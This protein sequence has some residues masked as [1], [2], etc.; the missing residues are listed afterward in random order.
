MTDKMITPKKKAK[1]A[2]KNTRIL[3]ILD[4]S[5]SMR[6]IQDET[7]G[8][9]NAF[10]A[11]QK[12][13]P[14]KATVSLMQFDNEFLVVHNNADIQTVPPL[15]RTT[16]VPR[17]C[18][19]LYD[20]VGKTIAE[21]KDNNPKSTK[22][23]VMI[24]TDGE[25]NSSKE[26]TYSSV[27]TLIEEVE[28]KHGWDVI[29][30]GANMNAA[31][32]GASMGISAARSATFDYSKGGAADAMASVNYATTSLRGAGIGRTYADGMSLNAANLDM[33]KLYN[34]VKAKAFVDTPVP[35]KP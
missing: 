4:R 32:V 21:F 6:S 7:I 19:S 29:F 16:F 18:T 30:L 14:G 2:P 10:L 22:T 11:E 12:S 9:F 8:G 33:S 26:Y 23:I 28:G 17:G 25:E 1:K 15:D 24:L 5:G 20:A 31:A 35:P 27:R 3:F 13:L 34:D